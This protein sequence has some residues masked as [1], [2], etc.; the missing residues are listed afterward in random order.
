MKRENWEQTARQVSIGGLVSGDSTYLVD[1]NKQMSLEGKQMQE[2]EDGELNG[3]YC[4]LNYWLTID[5][6][7]FNKLTI[8]EGHCYLFIILREVSIIM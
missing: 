7:V 8:N 1:K 2:E 6:R 5:E 4:S 3:K